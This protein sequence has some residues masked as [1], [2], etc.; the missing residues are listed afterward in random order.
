MVRQPS[1]RARGRRRLRN[2]EA[3]GRSRPADAEPDHAV[4]PGLERGDHGK[5][6]V[7]VELPLDAGD[8][9]AGHAVALV[10][11]VECREDII[12][13]GFR[14]AMP[15][16]QMRLRADEHLGMAHV[17]AR[18]AIEIGLR[19][20]IEVVAGLQHREAE[21]EEVEERLQVVERI[22]AAQRGRIGVGQLTPLRCASAIRVSGS[23]EPSRCMCN[24]ALGRLA[25]K[26]EIGDM[27]HLLPWMGAGAYILSAVANAAA[28][29]EPGGRRPC[30]GA[31]INSRSYLSWLGLVSALASLRL[32]WQSDPGMARGLLKTFSAT[33]Y[34]ALQ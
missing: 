18:G 30:T 12:D 3:D 29:E 23:S 11:V 4:A 1:R 34:P 13:D 5:R 6:V 19:H 28:R 26:G 25:M 2:F 14:S 10:G 32:A 7:F 31:A 17:F 22:G 9:A 27:G 20:P 8:Q 21:I 15:A 16:P 24:S 33:A